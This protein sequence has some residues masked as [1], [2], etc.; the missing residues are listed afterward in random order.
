MKLGAGSW[1]LFNAQGERW[2]SQEFSFQIPLADEGYP[3]L[4]ETLSLG[5]AQLSVQIQMAL[6]RQ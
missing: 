3:A 2:L 1:E 5:L 4:V 6:V